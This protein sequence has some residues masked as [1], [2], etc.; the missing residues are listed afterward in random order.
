MNRG[1][2]L[3]IFVKQSWMSFG[4]ILLNRQCGNFELP[5][6]SVVNYLYY[7]KQ[8]RPNIGKG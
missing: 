3:C 8:I 5:L 7:L 4:P 6:G 1:Y 2:H